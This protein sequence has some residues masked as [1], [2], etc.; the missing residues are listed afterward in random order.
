MLE[1]GF[2][3]PIGDDLPSLIPLI[4]ALLLFFASFNSALSRYDAVNKDIADELDSLKVARILRSDGYIIDYKEFSNLCGMV[5]VG[6]IDY[7]AGILKSQDEK[8]FGADNQIKSIE[9]LY[10]SDGKNLFYCTNASTDDR[11]TTA[12]FLDGKV[13]IRTYPIVIEH[14]RQDNLGVVVMP[15]ELS[16]VVWRK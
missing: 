9:D 1:K 8:I 7:E 6:S 4:F 12:N 10:Y 11:V 13:L 3:G 2:L 15:A 16:V 5:T 14:D